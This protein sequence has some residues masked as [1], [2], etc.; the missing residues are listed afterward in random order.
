MTLRL[1]RALLVVLLALVVLGGGAWLLL[2]R[3]VPQPATNDPARLFDHG[4]IGNEAAQGL[5]YWIWRV[6][7]QVFPD[8]LPADQDGYGAFG[9]F[10]PR[11]D[12]TPVGLSIK[13]LGVIPRVARTAPSAIRAATV[14]PRKTRR[15]W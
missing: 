9:L 7:P 2:L 10:W 3:P 6:L 12:A 8:L 13:T 14:S 5:P 11:G 15:D 4:S 1:W